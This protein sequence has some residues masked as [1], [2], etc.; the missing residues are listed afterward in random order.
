MRVQKQVVLVALVAFLLGWPALEVEASSQAP[1]TLIDDG[2]SKT[3]VFLPEVKITSLDGQFGS[4]AGARFG[5]MLD[6]KF[7]I[8]VGGFG[9]TSPAFLPMGYG[10]VV[11]EYLPFSD[12]VTHVSFGALVGGGG[13]STL[14]FAVVEPEVR[15]NVNVNKW[16]RLGIGGGYRF[17]AGGGFADSV[18][19][20][21]TMTFSLGFGR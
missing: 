11:V 13:L 10:G 9:V 8:G 20:G 2:M 1:K 16:L 12:R 17:I 14:S 5:L 21:P 3:F 7:M 4:L 18:L 19:R 15:L 6:H